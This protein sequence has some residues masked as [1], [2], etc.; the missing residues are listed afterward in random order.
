MERV[1]AVVRLLLAAFEWL[2]KLAGSLL[3]KLLS[4][5]IWTGVSAI[6]SAVALY[7]TIHPANTMQP[8]HPTNIPH[9]VDAS[10]RRLIEKSH[11][12]HSD[13]P[14]SGSE[15]A[16]YWHFGNPTWAELK[17]IAGSGENARMVSWLASC[18]YCEA[19]S[20]ISTRCWPSGELAKQYGWPKGFVGYSPEYRAWCK[21]PSSAARV[22]SDLIRFWLELRVDP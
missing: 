2:I 6:I 20:E 10:N 1:Q 21:P 17:R 8:N 3:A 15:P 13:T 18:H 4:H 14:V 5:S 11:V 19:E 9:V 7:V 16:E 22:D 12:T